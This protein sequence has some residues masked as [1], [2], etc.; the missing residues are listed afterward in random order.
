MFIST[1]KNAQIYSNRIDSN[2]RGILYYVNC[3]AVGGGAIG[4]DLA[5]NSAHGNTIIVSSQSGA[6]AN[7]FSYSSACSSTQAAPYM[8]GS[9]NLTFT[10]NSYSVPSLGGRY[11]LF[12]DSVK[13]WGQ[14]QSLGLDVEGAIQ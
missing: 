7:G 6:F 1:S 4:F 8:N 3:T 12:W 2:F 11:W 14:W 13:Y 10:R 5:N 9:K